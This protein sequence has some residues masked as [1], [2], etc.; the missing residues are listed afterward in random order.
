LR[1]NLSAAA[2]KVN[3]NS[4]YFVHISRI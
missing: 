1:G 2:R 4:R 3:T